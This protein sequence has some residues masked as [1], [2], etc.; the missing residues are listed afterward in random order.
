MLAPQ[1]WRLD[2]F[3]KDYPFMKVRPGSEDLL[4]IAGTF[5]FAAEHPMEGEVEDA[6]R[7]QIL[8]PS[9]FP[10]RLPLVHEVVGRI[11]GPG[12]PDQKKYHVNED[13]TFCLGSPLR[14]KLS[15]SRNPTLSEFAENCIVPYLF[16]VSRKLKNGGEF[17][18]GE[19][20]HGNE[21]ALADYMDLL[22]LSSEQQVL[23]SLRLLGMKRQ[24]ANKQPCPC[25]C[26][27]RL[28]RCPYRFHLNNLRRALGRSYVCAEADNISKYLKH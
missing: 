27:K 8:I 17:A 5:K 9:D 16:A 25:F 18:F 22:R 10:K 7:L 23:L 24:E 12:H 13:G 6:F 14:L 28:G 20:A 1:Q 15:L 26:G 11:P 2:V 3:M 21:G 19:L 4:C